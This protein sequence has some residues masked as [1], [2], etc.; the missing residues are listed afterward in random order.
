[1]AVT[2]NAVVEVFLLKALLEVDD[3]TLAVVTEIVQHILAGM[4][5]LVVVTPT[6]GDTESKT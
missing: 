1:M 5:A 4:L 6:V 2:E 3:D